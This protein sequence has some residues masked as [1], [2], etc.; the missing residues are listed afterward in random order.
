MRAPSLSYWS[1]LYCSS[2]LRL[3][4]EPSELCPAV[5]A[6]VVD[7]SMFAVAMS[8]VVTTMPSTWLCSACPKEGCCL[9]NRVSSYSIGDEATR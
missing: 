7:V 1:P 4:F 8:S 6:S 3:R 5:A 9:A 2:S